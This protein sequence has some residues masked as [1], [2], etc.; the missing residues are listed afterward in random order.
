VAAGWLIKF[1]PIINII[2]IKPS[3]AGGE[4]MAISDAFLLAVLLILGYKSGH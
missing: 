4:I 2:Y 3:L 1:N